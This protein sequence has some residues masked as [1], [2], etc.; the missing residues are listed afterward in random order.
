MKNI[1][2]KQ[3]KDEKCVNFFL[4]YAPLNLPGLY[5]SPDPPFLY[6]PPNPPGR[7]TYV[8][9]ALKYYNRRRKK[10]GNL[11]QYITGCPSLR[12]GGG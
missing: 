1:Y 9:H 7:G 4:V 12:G 11:Y 10:F 6:S 2:L 5:S 8:L 3:D